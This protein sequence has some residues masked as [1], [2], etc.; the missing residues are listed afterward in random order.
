MDIK[1]REELQLI[2]RE[3][4]QPKEKEMV[5]DIYLGHNWSG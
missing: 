3:E 1:E 2:F 4:I 5:R